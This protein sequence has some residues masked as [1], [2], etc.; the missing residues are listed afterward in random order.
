MLNFL[1]QKLDIRQ[2]WETPLGRAFFNQESLEV[3]RLISGIFGYHILL[4]GEPHFLACLQESTI[5]HRVWIHPNAKSEADGS[6]LASRFDKLPVIS[7][8]V[9]LV[10]LAHCLEFIKNPHEVLRETFRILLPEGHLI[11]SGFNPWS[12][13]GIGR[14]LG[15]WT[16]RAPWHGSFISAARMKDWLS[17]LGFDVM[18]TSPYFFRPPINH[19][20]FQQ[21]T[22][23]LEK[24]GRF[25]WPFGHGGYV[26]L[27]RKRVITLTPIRPLFQTTRKASLAAEPIGA[28]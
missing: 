17:L 9:D 20:K 7:D 10:Y 19:T 4:M 21:K 14:W 22:F 8:G 23:W 11:I 15:G 6:A 18:Q 1:M 5:R 2:W 25:C 24:V 28:E 16:K 3:K 12:L 27:A 26:I 13:W